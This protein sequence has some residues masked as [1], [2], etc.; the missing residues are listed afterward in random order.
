MMT[1]VPTVLSPPADVDAAF[2]AANVVIVASTG[3]IGMVF[4]EVAA[5]AAASAVVAA[6]VRGRRTVSTFCRVARGL[7]W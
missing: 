7:G 2:H 1:V 5:A 4:S 3:I 6:V